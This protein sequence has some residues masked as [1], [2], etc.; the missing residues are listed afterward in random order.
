MLFSYARL[1]KNYV[2][3]HGVDIRWSKVFLLAAAIISL[4]I[5]VS[6][7][8]RCF[9]EKR[10]DLLTY[11]TLGLNWPECVL[12]SVTPYLLS[13]VVGWIVGLNLW[14]W[15]LSIHYIW[16]LDYGNKNRVFLLLIYLVVYVVICMVYFFL[17]SRKNPIELKKSKE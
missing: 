9:T 12:V 13:I 16:A 6:V 10:N 3:D 1:E 17:Y 14:K 8:V 5:I 7:L 11:Y 15:Y 2:S 4:T